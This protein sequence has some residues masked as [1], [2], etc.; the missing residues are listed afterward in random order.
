MFLRKLIGFFISQSGW[1]WSEFPRNVIRIH[2]LDY[3][4]WI[5]EI[6][7]A[8]EKQAVMPMEP[9]RV[10]CLDGG[11]MRGVYQ[12]AYLDAVLARL[13]GEGRCMQPID[14]G[15]C[16]DLIVGT[17]TGAIVACALASGKEPR[18]VRLLYEMHGGH[19]FPLQ[20]LRAVPLLNLFI[21]ASGMGNR[22]G[23][24]KLR[25]ALEGELGE[26]TFADVLEQRGIALAIPTVDMARHASVVFKTRHLNRLNGRDDR[27]TLVDAC[28]ASTAAPI[29]R[30]LA[31]LTEPDTGVSVVYADGGLWAN[32]PGA[33]GAIESVEICRSAGWPDRRI[34]LFMLGSLPVQGGEEIGPMSR[35]RGALGWK[36]GLKIMDASINAQAIGYDYIAKKI[37]ELR[38]DGSAAWRL[39]AQCPSNDLRKYLSNMDD[40]RPKVLNALARQAVSDVDYLWAAA[41]RAEASASAFIEVFRSRLSCNRGDSNV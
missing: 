26:M 24:T 15:R 36:F 38:G 3:L 2:G 4:E 29:L 23:E 31:K 39:P 5:S 19:I 33:L 10:L 11:G 41:D 17:S 34:H 12:A 13:V 8:D 16:F 22:S 21:R 9:F 14:V 40:A 25:A 32:N 37:L 1:N 35:C 30:A 20:R 27:R 7:M 18:N 6:F 28:M